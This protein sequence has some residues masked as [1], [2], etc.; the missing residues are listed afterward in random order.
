MSDGDKI[1]N[2][3]NTYTRVDKIKLKLTTVYRRRE[4]HIGD[5][6]EARDLQ[7]TRHSSTENTKTN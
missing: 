3:K 5:W 2:T 1:L 4:L 6:T 7:M